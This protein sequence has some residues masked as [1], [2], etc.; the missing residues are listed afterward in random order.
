[1]LI[2]WGLLAEFLGLLFVSPLTAG[3]CAGVAGNLPISSWYWRIAAFLAMIFGIAL[4]RI[5]FGAIT[6]RIQL[7][8]T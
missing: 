1:M 3:L 5:S 8:R 4:T 7:R 2:L 6:G